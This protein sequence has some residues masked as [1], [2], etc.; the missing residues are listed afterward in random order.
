M[1]LWI[2][3]AIYAVVAVGILASSLW[4]DRDVH[5]SA[6]FG[7]HFATAALWPL[8]LFMAALDGF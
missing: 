3:F 6:S 4:E 7:E 1:W 5:G 2:I 8:W